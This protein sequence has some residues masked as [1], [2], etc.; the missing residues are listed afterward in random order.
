LPNVT[1][2]VLNVLRQSSIPSDIGGTAID[3]DLGEMQTMA[4]GSSS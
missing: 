2:H 3:Q 4:P 1:E